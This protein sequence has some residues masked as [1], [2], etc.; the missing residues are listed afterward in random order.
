MHA[1]AALET[2]VDMT[3]TA[4]QE[5]VFVNFSPDDIRGRRILIAED[6][7]MIALDLETV[8]E[9]LGCEIIGPVANVEDLVRQF[10]AHHP[11]GALL[12]INLRGKQVFAVL[13]QLI[14]LGLPVIITSGYDDI[15]LIPQDFR[16]LPR[17][18]K[19]FN[20]TALRELCVSVFAK[21]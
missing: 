10:E 21:R 16:T 19:P 6:E 5:S 17:I 14:G 18:S 11:D 7:A 9:D 2:R 12:D 8:L 4:S 15:T 1:P 3:N 13:P 20:Q